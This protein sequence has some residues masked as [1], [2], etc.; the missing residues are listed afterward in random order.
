MGN[1]SKPRFVYCVFKTAYLK[2]KHGTVVYSIPFM[3]RF[4]VFG[5]TK[6]GRLWGES[7]EQRGQKYTRHRGFVT[8]KAFVD[9]PVTDMSFIKFRNVSGVKIPTS[10]RYRGQRTGVIYPDE[11]VSVIAKVDGWMLT[12][13]GWTK[14]EWLRKE[15]E[16]YD[17]ECAKDL[18]YAVI[19]QT[20][21]DYTAIVKSLQNNTMHSQKDRYDCLTEFRMIRQWFHDGD[22]LKIFEDSVTGDE[23]LEML[24]KQL[25]VTKEWARQM[26]RKTKKE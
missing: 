9:C 24:D 8:K 2:D 11:V 12:V 4:R 20:V 19:T 21:T 26:L 16:F 23:R 10:L 18:V 13:K 6:D 15:A 22:Y 25:G 14:S 17:Y 3:G 7:L 1:E 5:E